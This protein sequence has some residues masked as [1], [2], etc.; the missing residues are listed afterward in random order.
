MKKIILFL[1]I[2]L[3]MAGTCMAEQKYNAWENRWETVPSN[4]E[5]KYNAWDNSWSYQPE[6][7]KTEYNAWE[8]K[9]D[10]DSGHGNSYK[11]DK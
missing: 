1:S 7:A 11:E 10:W 8:N 4:W 6:N 9:W 3:A 2:L 5:T